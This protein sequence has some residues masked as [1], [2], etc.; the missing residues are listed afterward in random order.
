M[1]YFSIL[2][3]VEAS[4]PDDWTKVENV[5][6]EDGHRQLYVFHEDAAISLAWG[7][8]YLDGEPWTEA[9]SESGGFP[10]KKIHG[11][12]LDIRYNG[13][14]IQRDLVLSVDGGRCVLPSGSPIS[15]A[16]KGVIGM[17]VSE[18]EMQ[19]ARLLDGLLE[20]SQFDRYSASANI[21]F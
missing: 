17:K 18:P 6:T 10:D 20:H 11:H 16:G 14:P 3:K 4:S 12:W 13:V 2:T 7:K 15:E 8:D 1:N 21:Q 9:W 19:R 5:T